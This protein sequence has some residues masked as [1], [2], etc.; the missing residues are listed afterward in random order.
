[1][2]AQ[3]IDHVGIVVGGIDAVVARLRARGTELVGK[4]ERHENVHRLCCVRDP[5]GTIAELAER[6]G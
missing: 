3:R 2:A 1:M 6:I 4:V 5:G